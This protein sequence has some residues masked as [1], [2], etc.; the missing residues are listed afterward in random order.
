MKTLRKFKNTKISYELANKYTAYYEIEAF[1]SDPT[2]DEYTIIANICYDT[3]M[4]YENIALNELVKNVVEA[5]IDNK[6]T[7]DELKKI[8]PH[9]VYCRFW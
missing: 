5:Y 1:I 9:D 3:Y 7:L 2:D 4:K 8:S 6:I